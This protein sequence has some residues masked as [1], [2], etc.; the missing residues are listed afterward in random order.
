[1]RW[2]ALTAAAMALLIAGFFLL[3][4]GIP[5]GGPHFHTLQE[6][7]SSLLALEVAA[8]ALVRYYSR[9]SNRFLLL[10]TAF[11]GAAFLDTYHALATSTF[12]VERFQSPELSVSPWS[13]LASRIFLASLLILSS[14]APRRKDE[15][16]FNERVVYLS[17]AAVSLASFIFF[18]FTPL[19]SAYFPDLLFPR[20]AELIPAV[21]FLLAGLGFLRSGEWRRSSFH[22]WLLLS[23]FLSFVGQAVFMPLSQPFDPFYNTGHL[24]KNLSYLCAL[25]ALLGSMY[26]LFRLADNSAV[27]LARINTALQ[28]EVN[29]RERAEQERDRFFLLSLDMLCIAGFDGYFKQLNP[30]WE[31]TLGRPLAELMSR[32]FVEFVHP[33]DVEPTTREAAALSV[34][35]R[36]VDFENRYRTGDGSYRWLSWRATSVPE[37]GL[38]Y[39]VAR[40]VDERKKI[41]Q[42]KNDFISVV[43]HELRT[44]LTSIR[45]SLGLLAGGVAGELPER[46]RP[47]VEIA[48]NNSERLVRLINDILDIE[49]IESG[50]MVFR[51][52]TLEVM[53]VVERAIEANRAYAHS[54]D[55]DFRIARAEPGARVWADA[56][57]LQQ[58]LTNL[59]SNA[60]KFS[61]HGGV[62]EVSVSR[63]EGRI[64]VSVSDRGPG[65]P[66]EFQARIFEKF[67]QADSSTTR[68]KG[69]TGLGLS[70]TKAIV[71]RHGGRI[72]Y[73][74][75]AETGTT[76][77]F[78]M[79]EWQSAELPAPELPALG[80]RV[81]V[82]E[83]DPDIA[84]LLKLMLEGDGYQA[85]VAHDAAEA[86]RLLREHEYAAMT[87]DLVLPGQDGISLLRELRHEGG[88]LPVVVV[89]VRADQGR[90]ELNGGALG[91]IDWLSKP[92]DQ[93]QL[94]DAVRRAVR[95]ASG[96]GARIL[97]VEDDP[98][99]RR[100]V[101]AIVGKDAAVESAEDL[102][103][104]RA[105]LSS[106]RF[107]LVLLD[108]ALPDGSG[109]DLLPL[110]SKVEPSTP[111]VIFSAHEVDEET[112]GRVA[113][114]LIKSQTSNPQLLERIRS[115]LGAGG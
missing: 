86:K 40:D 83:D 101:A 108:L 111:V 99:L 57:R 93:I 75:G 36:T 100:V 71:E 77:S 76:F 25:I 55:V 109:L 22:R 18:T 66:P 24:A 81:L 110:L 59:L 33:D 9:R 2:L 51:F 7:I 102:E 42:M 87:L 28:E 27:E 14:F 26:D 49:K 79:A 73:E 23:L 64:C 53:P 65:V 62:V 96:R 50:E 39:A 48:A 32:P 61:P 43:S 107:D 35:G 97:H 84:N 30:A 1:M 85:D 82:C 15:K 54:L 6:T 89:S 88:A 103:E 38:I 16:P 21:L 4:A 113:S 3:R 112:A 98:D 10:G 31:K 58:V 20:P 44:P 63:T 17:I 92:I 114:V 95:G 8:I 80:A 60:A 74:T 47:L 41:E 46:M 56:D 13:F 69:G 11:L 91:V 90:T 94:R 104:A 5:D 106:D 68:Q 115:V 105:K 70:I 72:W 78:D 34:G 52:A 45:G 19:P 12:F 29:E 37:Q 67:A